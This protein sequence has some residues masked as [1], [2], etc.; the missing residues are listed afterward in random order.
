MVFG[1]NSCSFLLLLLVVETSFLPIVALH[2]LGHAGTNFVFTENRQLSLYTL[3][4]IIIK[5]KS[6]WSC[7]FFIRGSWIDVNIFIKL[8][9]YCHCAPLL[10]SSLTGTGEKGRLVYCIS[11]QKTHTWHSWQWHRVWSK[12]ARS[13]FRG[14]H[15]AHRL[16]P[17]RCNM[18]P[19]TAPAATPCHPL[20]PSATTLMP[21]P[22]T[23]PHVAPCTDHLSCVT[24][25]AAWKASH[26]FRFKSNNN[27]GRSISKS[28]SLISGLNSVWDGCQVARPP[29][30]PLK[31]GGRGGLN[32][33]RASSEY[34][35]PIILINAP[36]PT[37][38]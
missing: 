8:L 26:K 9:E 36:S 3:R 32:Q 18:S 16:S 1:S 6:S 17:A 11:E 13:Y 24:C 35:N 30:T 34:Q 20:L 37:K 4:K 12:L 2:N 28:L 15:E 21:P 29:H 5:M 38:I 31:R 23:H 25:A 14:L 33:Y 22:A 10:L 27:F 7:Q 19:P